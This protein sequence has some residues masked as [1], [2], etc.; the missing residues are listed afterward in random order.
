MGKHCKHQNISTIN[1]ND[2]WQVIQGELGDQQDKGIGSTVHVFAKC[3]LSMQ[4]DLNVHMVLVPE[5]PSV[6]FN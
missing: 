3:L 2:D 6:V 1:H 5:A 4:G